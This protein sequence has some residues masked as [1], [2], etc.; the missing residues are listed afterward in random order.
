MPRLLAPLVGAFLTLYIGDI[1]HLLAAAPAAGLFSV[2]RALA[3]LPPV[4]ITRV[5]IYLPPN[6]NETMNQST[7][8]LNGTPR[9]QAAM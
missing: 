1:S 8:R 5:G 9:I 2:E 4:K 3:A 6:L 7:I